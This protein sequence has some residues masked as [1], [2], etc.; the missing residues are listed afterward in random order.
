MADNEKTAPD[1]TPGPDLV[2][3]NDSKKSATL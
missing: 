2:V 3:L 1:S